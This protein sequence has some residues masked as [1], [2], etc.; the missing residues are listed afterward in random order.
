M[1]VFLSLILLKVHIRQ[2][3]LFLPIDEK[4][5]YSPGSKR[6]KGN[7]KPKCLDLIFQYN[8]YWA[9]KKFR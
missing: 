7:L 5:H 4:H 3:S 6:G 9:T 2:Y 8:Y 1:R